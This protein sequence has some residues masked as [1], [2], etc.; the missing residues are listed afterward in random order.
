MAN[1]DGR[2]AI[3]TGAARGIGAAY[4]KALSANGARTVI[5]DILDPQK[6]VDE[7]TKTGGAAIAV[8]TDV[9][10]DESLRILTERTI[11][12]FGKID[13]CVTNAALFADLEQKP[14]AEIDLDEWDRVMRINVRGVFQTVKA[15]VPHMREQ[16]Y[17]KIVNIASATVFKGVP[18]LLHYVSSK[19][20]IVAFTR[21]LAREVGDDG[22]CVTA[23][24][25]GLTMSENLADR[26]QWTRVKDANAATRAFKRDELPED[27][28]GTLL[29]LASADSDFVTG[30][31]IV[32]DGGSVMH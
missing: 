3:V 4:A 29:F 14:F 28:T 15:V 18:M 27:L 19:G 13:I 12:E 25:P 23:I 2:V 20:A 16:R 22:I 5:A 7:I 31:T 30:Q 10:D 8:E 9:A 26:E 6:T 1:L 17:G 24:A 32:V 21:A 11:A